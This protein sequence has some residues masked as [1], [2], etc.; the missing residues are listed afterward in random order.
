MEAR[1]CVV[2]ISK[3]TFTTANS[4]VRDRKASRKTVWGPAYRTVNRKPAA[5][6]AAGKAVGAATPSHSALRGSVSQRTAVVA[7]SPMREFALEIRSW[8]AP[9]AGPSMCR[10]AASAAVGSMLPDTTTACQDQRVAA[11]NLSA[12]RECVEV[13]AVVASVGSA[14]LSRP[15]WRE[16]ASRKQTPRQMPGQVPEIRA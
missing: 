8:P 16:P 10:T 15:A 3:M 12:K 6:M 9:G 13:M 5:E 7:R 4:A 11:V 14:R 2:G 1:N